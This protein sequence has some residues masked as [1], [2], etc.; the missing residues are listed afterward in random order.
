MSTVVARGED[1]HPPPL[2]PTTETGEAVDRCDR[3]PHHALARTA[4]VTLAATA[5]ADICA[6]V[7]SVYMSFGCQ[8]SRRGVGV[9]RRWEDCGGGGGVSKALWRGSQARSPEACQASEGL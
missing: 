2:A 7:P 5:S 3:L 4:A 9:G 6:H 1:P 8:D